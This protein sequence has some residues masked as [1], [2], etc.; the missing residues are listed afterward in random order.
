MAADSLAEIDTWREPDRVLALAEWAVGPRPGSPHRP[1]A[2]RSTT[3]FGEAARGS[4][5][6]DGPGL[7]LSSTEIRGRV[8]TGRAIRYLVPRAVEELIV[9][10]QLYRRRATRKEQQLAEP[11]RTALTIRPSWPPDRRHRVGQEGD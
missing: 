7:D 2:T 9:D 5:C 3:R 11:A 6:C 8:A 1:S 10:R 4:T